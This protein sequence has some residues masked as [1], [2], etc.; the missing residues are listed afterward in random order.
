M[1]V[2]TGWVGDGSAGVGK[3]LW[4]RGAIEDCGI[5]NCWWVDVIAMG[6]TVDAVLFRDACL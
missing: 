4:M 5:R 1:P 2:F 6:V 3:R